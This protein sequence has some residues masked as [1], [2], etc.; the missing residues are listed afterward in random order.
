MNNTSSPQPDFRQRFTY[1]WGTNKL[2][3]IS[4]IASIIAMFLAI[5][6]LIVFFAI[7]KPAA[8]SGSAQNSKTGSSF[9]PSASASTSASIGRAHMT[10]SHEFMDLVGQVHQLGF[11]TLRTTKHLLT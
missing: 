1:L 8:R 7:I 2:L 9:N 4:I 5:I 3:V 11:Q 10:E 6:F